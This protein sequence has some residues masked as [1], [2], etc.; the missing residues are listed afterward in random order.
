M[1]SWFRAAAA[2]LAAMVA[3][4]AHAQPAKAA[5]PIEVRLESRLV[6]KA[7]DGKDAFA[8]ADRARPGD[9]V[10]YV[11][12]Y[13]NTSRQAVSNLQATVPIPGDMEFIAGSAQ[14][15]SANASTDGRAYAPLPLRRKVER[16]GV[17]AEELV[18][19]GDYRY[20]RWTVPSLAP[21]AT[22]RFTARA[23]IRDERPTTGPPTSTGGSR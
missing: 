2:L 16:N 4:G 13:R 3:G 20:L 7:A 15:A 9:V 17:Q 19:A 1:K 23:R 21:D 10:E 22:V 8:S 12:T 11:A 6:T 14:P 5:D 18:P